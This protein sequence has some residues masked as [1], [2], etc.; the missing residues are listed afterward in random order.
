V[1]AVCS[2]VGEGG[3]LL[4]L[5]SAPPASPAGSLAT[6]SAVLPALDTPANFAAQS[7]DRE[8]VCRLPGRS[9]DGGPQ[10]PARARLPRCA[11]TGSPGIVSAARGRRALRLCIARLRRSGAERGC[12]RGP[13]T[14]RKEGQPDDGR[15]QTQDGHRLSAAHTLAW[16][17]RVFSLSLSNRMGPASRRP[18]NDGRRESRAPSRARERRTVPASNAVQ[19]LLQVRPGLRPGALKS[20]CGPRTES[21]DG[22]P[23]SAP[24]TD[25][26]STSRLEQ[27]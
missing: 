23:P 22:L 17:S 25:T 5:V 8:H 20:T 3:A 1:H 6:R 2:C 12:A 7:T 13:G 10:Q 19:P 4:A 9:S 14:P 21:R 18:G 15:R 11:S 27:P 24:A 16:P 26:R